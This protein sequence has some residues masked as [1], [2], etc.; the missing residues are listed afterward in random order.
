MRSGKFQNA[1]VGQFD[2]ARG[3][4]RETDWL[5]HHRNVLIRPLAK[6][7]RVAPVSN[8][9]PCQIAAPVKPILL[10]GSNEAGATKVALMMISGRAEIR[11]V[12]LIG[13]NSRRLN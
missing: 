10:N 6:I 12:A 9:L 1:L 2:L 4:E 13:S 5:P 8:D 11:S 3:T 7:G